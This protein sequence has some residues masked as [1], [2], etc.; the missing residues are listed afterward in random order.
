[1][2]RDACWRA[3]A[4][5]RL[6][7]ADLL[8]GLTDAQWEQP[9]LCAGWRVRDVAS[10]LVLGANPPGWPTRL[11]WGLRKA[12][13]F[14]PLNR[15]VAIHYADRPAGDLVADLRKHAD[16]RRVPAPI[17]V[18][19][20]TAL[21]DVLVHG[22]DIAIPLGLRR[23]MPLDAARVAADRAWTMGWPFWARRRLRGYRISATDCDWAAGE[24]MPVDGPIRAILL[25]L[26]GRLGV[27]EL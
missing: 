21:L 19:H 9:S 23:D 5:E 13:R 16:S 27:S 4:A 8:D 11:G 6:S 2:D 7:L 26:T 12:G 15:D 3:V 22:Q 17:V 1:M 14:H 18:D 10:H 20:R 24:G 25:L